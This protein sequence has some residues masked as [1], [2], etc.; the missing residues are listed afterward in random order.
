MNGKLS[1]KIKSIQA[2]IFSP[3]NLSDKL[4]VAQGIREGL[5]GILDGEPLIMPIPEDAP[6]EIPRIILKSKDGTYSCNVNTGR[7]GLIFNEKSEPKLS[8]A[9]AKKQI[10]PLFRKLSE[11]VVDQK[12]ANEINRLGLVFNFFIKLSESGTKFLVERFLKQ[13]PSGPPYETRIHLLYHDR[14]KN[15]EIN[16]WIKIS[17]LR[18]VK[19]KSD[20]TAL[21]FIIDINTSSEM[22]ERYKFNKK[23]ID[24]FYNE[25]ISIVEKDLQKYFKTE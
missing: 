9:N 7:I 21:S 2:A 25:S 6:P 24:N 15:Y 17:P 13:I 8:L 14:I 18:K 5:N 11:I 20:D 16:K 1:P 3:I 23:A 22:I 19:D 10:L 12:I 4:K